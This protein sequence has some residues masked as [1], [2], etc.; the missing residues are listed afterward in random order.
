VKSVQILKLSKQ[1]YVLKTYLALLGKYLM[2]YFV[3]FSYI[4][5]P[6]ELLV[7]TDNPMNYVFHCEAKENLVL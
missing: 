2:L 5:V 3:G 1:Q 6:T 4:S 7:L